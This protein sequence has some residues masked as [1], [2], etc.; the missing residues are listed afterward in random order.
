MQTHF[1]LQK[2]LHSLQIVSYT[3]PSSQ[4]IE[5]HTVQNFVTQNTSHGLE[6]DHGLLDKCGMHIDMNILFFPFKS[7]LNSSLVTTMV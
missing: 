1:L 3:F 2:L 6:I 7:S 5:R 4:E